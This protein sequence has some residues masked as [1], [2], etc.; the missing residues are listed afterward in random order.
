MKQRREVLNAKEWT[1]YNFSETDQNKKVPPPPVCKPYP[2]D[3]LIYDLPKPD[4]WNWDITTDFNSATLRRNSI[5]KFKDEILKL[6]ELSYLLW[7]T[8]AVRLKINNATAKRFVPSAG[9]RHALETYLA[10][11]NV[12]DLPQGIYRYLP[13]EHKLLFVYLPELF[14]EAITNS[15][16]GQSFCT[17]ANVVFYWSAIPYRMEW[18]YSLASSKLILLDAGHVCQNL[19]LASDAVKCGT[20]AIAAYDQEAADQLLKLDGE[21]ELVIYIAPVGKIY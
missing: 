18:R 21:E 20:C 1:S 14:P 3:G 9:S 13:E 19:Y 4:H 16:K 17:Q 2:K 7:S 15:V 8:Q 6:K 5:R 12:Q 11:L 10:V